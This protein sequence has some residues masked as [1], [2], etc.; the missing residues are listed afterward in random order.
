[1]IVERRGEGGSTSSLSLCV[2]KSISHLG[3]FVIRSLAFMRW[4]SA[5]FGI[6]NV[7]VGLIDR[8]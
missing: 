7:A 4:L 3:G 8:D 2:G 6:A 1:M 5:P